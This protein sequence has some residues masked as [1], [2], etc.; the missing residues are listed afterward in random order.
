MTEREKMLSGEYYDPSDAELVKLRLEAR[1]LTEKLNQTSV[2]CPDKRVEIVKSLLGS[3]GNSIHIE[4][5]F[6]CDYGLNI[7]VGENFYA[8]FGCVIL[9]VAE[10]RIGE[11]CFIA[12]QVGIYTATHPIDPIQRNSGVEFAKP[13]RIGNNCW[14]GGHATINPGVTLGDNVV[15]ASGAVVTKSFGSNV[16]IG[17]NP[18]RVLKAIE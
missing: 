1:L 4:S 15:V 9:D 17:G 8:N 13:I 5:T 18:A 10:V 7:H 2:S 3:T 16:V 12:P 11:N 14:I 6:N